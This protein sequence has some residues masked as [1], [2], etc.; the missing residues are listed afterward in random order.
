MATAST[1]P[2]S[3]IT[4]DNDVVTAEIF[5]AAPRD[6]VFQAITDPRQ[7]VKWWGQEGKYRLSEFNMDVRVGG[8][9]S[10]AGSSVTMGGPIAIHGEFLAVDPPRELSYTWTSSWMPVS[11]QVRWELEAQESGTIL[12]L[13]HAG[14]GGNAEQAKNHS[15]GWT[16]VISWLRSFVEKGE[17]I[18]NRYK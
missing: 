8:K 18:D 6:R 11:T 3:H 2:I 14:F 13:T 1:T 7:A 5:I 12:R 15:I 10:C 16:L 17:T 4:P 9:W